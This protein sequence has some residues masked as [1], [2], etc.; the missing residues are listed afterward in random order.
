MQ[1]KLSFGCV[2]LLQSSRG[3]HDKQWRNR[4]GGGQRLLTGKF[5]KKE[6]RKNG[7]RRKMEKKRKEG[8]F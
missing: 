4:R 6:A 1:G 8:K 7:K 3:S 2:T 5:L